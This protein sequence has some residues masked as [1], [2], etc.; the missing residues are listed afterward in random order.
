MT[1]FPLSGELLSEQK[2]AEENPALRVMWTI[3]EHIIP[4]SLRNNWSPTQAKGNL[5][6]SAQ[7]WPNLGSDLTIVECVLEPK[8]GECLEDLAQRPFLRDENCGIYLLA[9]RSLR[10]ETACSDSGAS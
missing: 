9:I 7:I 8:S 3:N 1:Q 10:P 5:I 6:I 4:Q 2:I